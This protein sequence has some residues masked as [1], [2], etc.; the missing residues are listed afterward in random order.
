MATQ[1]ENKPTEKKSATPAEISKA[2]GEVSALLAPFT[3]AEQARIIRAAASING[4]E[5][6]KGGKR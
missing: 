6:N 5:A 4:L 3:A 1:Q 2:T